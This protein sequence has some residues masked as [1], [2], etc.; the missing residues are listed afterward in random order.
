MKKTVLFLFALTLLSACAS[1]QITGQEKPGA[2]IPNH[3]YTPDELT[4]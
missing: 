3:E 2:S 1:S 4:R